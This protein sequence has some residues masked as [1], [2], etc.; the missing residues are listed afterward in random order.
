[1][2]RTTKAGI[3]TLCLLFI[4]FLSPNTYSQK[5]NNGND[6]LILG[7]NSNTDLP[8]FIKLT[9]G[10]EIKQS[11]FSVW[12]LGVLELPSVISF[13][14]YSSEK[15]ELGYVHTRYREYFNDYQVNSTMLITHSKNGVIESIN[16]DYIKQF[17]TS[18]T[19]QI[20]EEKAL[21]N[22]LKKINAK[23]YKWENKEEEIAMR[24]AL[25]NPD[26]TYKPKG[27]L[28]IAH[29]KDASYSSENMRLAYKFD[30]YAEVP[31]Y[32]ANVF[33][34]A[35]TGAVILE[36][37]L[38]HF[39]DVVGTANTRYSGGKP[40]TS[41]NYGT[42]Q[43]RLR[44]TGRGNGISTYNCNNGT[45]YTN[46]DFTNTSSTWNLTGANQ[47][48]TDAHFGT[49]MTYDFYKQKFN[50]NSIDGNGYALLSYVH[51]DYNYENAFWD[52]TRMTY[53]DGN[54]SNSTNPFTCLDVCGHE[55]THGLTS[56]TAQLGGS[57]SGEPGA[58]NE[59]FSD[60]FGTCIEAF[61]RPT[62]HDWIMGADFTSN[63]MYQR[64]MANPSAYGQPDT[65]QGTNWDY[66]GE[67]HNNNGPSN[68]WFYLLCQGGTGTNDI[69][70]AYNVTGITM[71]K[72]SR[73][74]FRAL[75]VYFTS[76]TNYSAV[77][78]F[79]IQAA[80]DLYGICSQEVQSTTNAWYAV[81]VGGQYVAPTVTANFSA[82]QTVACTLPVTI[83]FNNTTANGSTYTW[84]FGD[85]TTSTVSNPSHTYTVAGMYNV[86]LNAIGCSGSTN[87]SEVKNNYI[88]INPLT[89]PTANG[90]SRC[91]PGT[92]NLSAT[93]TGTF[94]WHDAQGNV[95]N[96]GANFTT[97]SLS[98]NTTYYVSSVNQAANVTGGPASSSIGTAAAFSLTTRYLIFDVLQPC[99]LKTVDVNASGA[100]NRTIQLRDSLGNNLDSMVVN[101]PNG[102]STVTL[103]F[104]LNPGQK[105][106]LGLSTTSTANLIR[107]SAGAVFP[108]TIGSY[109][110]INGTNATAGYYYFYY[111]WVLQPSSCS[112]ASVPVVATINSTSSPTGAVTQSFCLASTIANLTATGSSIQWYSSSTG[113]SALSSST[114]LVNG[115]TYYASQTVSGC[116]SSTRLAVTVTVGAIPAPTGS[117][118]QSFCSA[119]TIANLTATGS[120]IQWYS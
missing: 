60:I 94:V 33:V 70:N 63:T 104:P 98:A 92:V 62:Q 83:Q 71:D 46:T 106:Q 112:S 1:M 103:N 93:G 52:G 84:D 20:S 78:G 43:Y 7:K 55:V 18:Y 2:K 114:A 4:L 89:A 65:Y 23:K 27:K 82:T 87:D 117:T 100:G 14:E 102:L 31:L 56:N 120:S 44:E 64:S 69:G 75:T 10:Q 37:D 16:G 77:R 74:A 80:I 24:E 95:V 99:T 105:Y 19:P 8:N 79:A 21:G 51:Y 108:Y 26:F 29:V 119:S 113:G 11:E 107:N 17:Q 5:V 90:A 61:A 42:N 9:K 72:A 81:G 59:S 40:L 96:T 66:G 41:D 76:N 58:L 34:D 50:R 118:T 15:D 13:K 68:F 67:V 91:G 48:A 73:I 54:P 85:G 3:G 12:V 22:A 36:E 25:K 53:G 57:G 47:V 116:E 45:S 97:P 115:A 86:S 6:I 39:A 49:E 32:H 109:V 38:I 30:I 88:V 111:N 101:M 28:V 35:I 110:S